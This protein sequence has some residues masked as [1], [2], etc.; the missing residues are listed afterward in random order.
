MRNA[1][2]ASPASHAKRPLSSKVVCLPHCPR[3]PV[4]RYNSTIGRSTGCWI[5]RISRKSLR[6]RRKRG[7]RYRLPLP[8]SSLGR[9]P[10]QPC[11]L[12][13]ILPLSWTDGGGTMNVT[14]LWAKYGNE[15]AED[16]LLVLALTAALVAFATTPIAFA[17][18]GRLDW[19]KARR[20][21]VMQRPEFSSIVV[22]MILVM[23]IPAIFAALVLKS[24]SF[25]KNRYEFDPNKTWSVLEQGRGLQEPGGGRRGGQARDGAAGAGAEEPG[26]Q[27]QEAGR[28]HARAAGRGRDVARGGPGVP[29][30][31][32]VAGRRPQERRRGRP[33]A[34]A[35]TS[36]RRRSSSGTPP[37][38][39]P[40]SDRP[41]SPRSALPA[42][43]TA[44]PAARDAAGNG[45]A[46]AQVAAELAAVPEPQ[47]AHRRHA[48]PGGPAAGL[49]RRQVGREATS[50]PSTPTTSTRRSTAAPRASS[51]TASR[52][53]RTPSTTR[54]ATRPTRSSST[55]SRWPTRSRPWAST[56][57]RSPTRPRSSPVGDRGLHHR[58]QHALLRRQVL[59]ADR[60]DPGRPQVRRLRP[61]AGQAGRR[62]AEAGWKRPHRR[63]PRRPAGRRHRRPAN[64]RPKA[65]PT[66]SPPTQARG[67]GDHARDLLRPPAGRGQ[68]GRR[69]VRRP[70]RLRLQLPL[71]RLHGRLQGRRSHL[72]GLPAPLP[73]RQGGQGG[74]REVRRGRQAGRGRDQD[75]HRP[76][77]PTR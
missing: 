57:R 10:S 20:G 45:L 39:I 70:G 18:L 62:Q 77:G 6:D 72:A 11:G 68:A 37:A 24:R 34:A 23:A 55:S 7:L 47:K 74:A 38:A 35:W 43:A 71:R 28:G 5:L 73:R 31:L 8:I 41:P 66:P 42:A 17:V 49:D 76:R 19:F 51:S 12:C 65:R 64:P 48:A 22:G 9:R 61:G 30:R 16:P 21:R 58:R 2:R 27:R 56:A 32:A 54:P 59:H 67:G 33:A 36:P 44:S 3:K 60:L 1:P 46:P 52:G 29:R 75:A 53:W 50:R 4:P 25:D 26:R 63:R 69:Q 40:G 13:E 15:L 14:G